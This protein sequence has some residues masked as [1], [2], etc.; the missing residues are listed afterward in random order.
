MIGQLNDWQKQIIVGSV[1]GGSSLVKQPKGKNYY[2]SMRSKDTLW[3]QYKMEEL[4]GCFKNTELKRDGR[5]Y[6]SN[7][8]CSEAFTELHKTLYKEGKRHINNDIL[9]MLTDTGMAVWFL[10]GGGLTGRNKKNAYI[11]TTKYGKIGSETIRSYFNDILDV[12]CNINWNK[13]R[14]RVVMKV[15]GTEK[16]LKTISHRFPDYM[17]QDDE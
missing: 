16:L 3:L 6:R 11:N 8:I 14:M 7:S 13:E 1:L 5:T 12:Y 9:D 10:E 15:D 2:L 4:K 17:L